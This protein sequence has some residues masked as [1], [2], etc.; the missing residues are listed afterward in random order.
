[1]VNIQVAIDCEPHAKARTANDVAKYFLSKFGRGDDLTVDQIEVFRLERIELS[2]QV[3]SDESI[4]IKV[5][6]STITCQSIESMI[7]SLTAHRQQRREALV[8]VNQ[9]HQEFYSLLR[10]IPEIPISGIR[11]PMSSAP[12]RPQTARTNNRR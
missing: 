7:E 11:R 1:M 5:P 6:D 3:H 10:N 12:R 4:I 2:D 8:T 9:L